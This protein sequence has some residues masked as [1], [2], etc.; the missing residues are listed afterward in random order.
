MILDTTVS[1]QIDLQKD[2]HRIFLQN[3]Q[4]GEWSWNERSQYLYKNSAIRG[5]N[6]KNLRTLLKGN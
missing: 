1:F 5:L 3:V 4:I 6:I 2:Q